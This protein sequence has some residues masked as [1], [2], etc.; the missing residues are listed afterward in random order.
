MLSSVAIY[1]SS[2]LLISE[3]FSI[4][5]L[6]IGTQ[7]F[8][9]KIGYFWQNIKSVCSTRSIWSLADAE[10]LCLF[11]PFYLTLHK[12]IIWP[13]AAPFQ[14]DVLNKP[15]VWYALCNNPA[16]RWH[17][18]FQIWIKNAINIILYTFLPRQIVHKVNNRQIFSR[19]IGFSAFPRNLICFE[20][21]HKALLTAVALHFCSA[22]N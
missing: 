2:V 22:V 5:S 15:I 13:K 20:G 10:S 3:Y 8:S 14:C 6:T 21:F 19:R 1:L 17:S 18:C 12:A 9:S 7:Y 16:F 11:P 4:M